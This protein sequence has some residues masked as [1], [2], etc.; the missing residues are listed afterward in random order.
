MSADTTF[1]TV[2]HGGSA[3]SADRINI[4]IV[5][6]E[7]KNLTVLESILDDP[8]YRLV[9]AETADQALLSL[10]SEDFA[11]IILDIRMP[12][13]TGFEL[14][15]MI[16]ERKKTSRVPIIFLTA[17]YQEDQHKLEGYDTGAVDYLHKPVNPS[18]LRSK[19]AVFADLNRKRKE[20]GSA[21]HALI[22][23]IAER[24][25]V[26]ER[27]R[28]LNETLE[29][30]VS[31]RTEALQEADNRK[32]EF[33]A[34]LA[35]ELRNPLAPIRNA[36]QILRLKGT[37]SGIV[38]STSEMMERQ[39]A[40]MVRLVDDLLDISRITRG[41][42]ELRLS[43]IELA[44]P[45][46][47]A[48]EAA[49][50]FMQE[51]DHEFTVTLTQQPIFV[52]GDPIRLAQVVGNLLNNA[53]KFTVKG[54]RIGLSLAQENEQAVIR[55]R[56][57]GKG[58]DADQLPRIFEMFVQFD[59]TLE[60]T[61]GGLGIGLSLVKNLVGMHHGTVEVNS[62]G[63]GLGS[64][65]VVRLPILINTIP[66]TQMP[67]NIEQGARKSRRILV[68]DDNV[69]SADS[70]ASLLKMIG[71]ETFTAYDGL[72]AVTS[73]ASIRPDVILL[74]IGMPKLDGY[75]ACRRIRENEWARDI[76]MVALTGWGQE[77]DKQKTKSAGFNSHLVKP[78][79]LDV[80]LKLL[81]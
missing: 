69:D 62:A 27:L 64:E 35:H 72:A 41:K 36:V 20:L 74:D 50:T 10:V 24:G 32:N 79:E 68:V 63:K 73:A 16:K 54:G 25:R 67:G 80:L 13:M 2:N 46:Y 66:S 55:V 29:K 58:I 51:K 21:N 78:V 76:M 37:D 56:D 48:V 44:S 43:R 33:L 81:S 6:D 39:L 49:K 11:L 40:Q 5:D 26:E 14:A 77:E 34:M 31:D 12:G 65:F 47:H 15:Q 59:S 70:L 30:R 38:A 17:Y 57:N 19:V 3:A 1:S 22:A 53:S 71:N 45:I 8:S 9:R 75:E 42:I 23:E 60:R 7:P 18:I 28:E 61:A 52:H 4:L